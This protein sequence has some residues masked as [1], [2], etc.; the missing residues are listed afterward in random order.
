[1]FAK[2]TSPDEAPSR[3]SAL[4]TAAP[5]EIR[6]PGRR[7][8]FTNKERTVHDLL[9]RVSDWARS[10]SNAANIIDAGNASAPRLGIV[11]AEQHVDLGAGAAGGTWRSRS[12][13]ASDLSQG[14]LQL[15]RVRVRDAMYAN[16]TRVRTIA[17]RHAMARCSPSIVMPGNRIRRSQSFAANP[18][19]ARKLPLIDVGRPVL[20]SSSLSL[21]PRTTSTGGL[22]NAKE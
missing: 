8:H 18:L 14:P 22:S 17:P 20:S 4:L 19:L 15:I 21:H 5:P 10:G 1:M 13:A 16:C 6:R 11:E 12:P 2:Y 7:V 3:P 9:R